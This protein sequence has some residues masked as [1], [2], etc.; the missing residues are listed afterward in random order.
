MRVKIGRA[1]LDPNL[2]LEKWKPSSYTPKG[3]P[4]KNCPQLHKDRYKNGH[5]SFACKNKKLELTQMFVSRRDREAV[6][7]GSSATAQANGG[8]ASNCSFGS[9][10]QKSKLQE[11]MQYETIYVELKNVKLYILEICN[12]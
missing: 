2:S 7:G 1:T 3:F 12:M 5:S 8:K 9:A 4:W 10:E 11:H 6:W